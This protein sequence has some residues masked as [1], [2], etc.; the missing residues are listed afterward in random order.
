MGFERSLA[1]AV[2]LSAAIVL[3][4]N[5]HA[6]EPKHASAGSPAAGQATPA[7]RLD[8]KALDLLKEMSA[9]LAAAKALSFTALTTYEGP[10]IY[11]PPLAY[12]TLSQVLLQRP[13]KLRVLTVGDGPPSEFYYDGKTMMAYEPEANLVAVAEAP[14]TIEG[15]LKA[16]YDSAAIYFPFADVVVADPYRDISE[17][18]KVAFYIGQSRVY[19]G[20]TTDMIAI[21]NERIF[22]Q[23]WIGAEDKLPRRLR[24]IYL[25]DP[26]RLRHDVELSNWNLDPQIP[27]DAFGSAKASAANKISFARPDPKPP[28][29]GEAAPKA[30]GKAKKP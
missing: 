3:A 29:G 5:A 13:D 23:V 2:L 16:A 4:G 28:G 24:A 12:Q 15:V 30:H 9:R 17:G 14:P 6:K 10:T 27:A 21:A 8:P 25:D 11:G 7:P 19:G 18:L 26:A 1:N 20:T 22:V